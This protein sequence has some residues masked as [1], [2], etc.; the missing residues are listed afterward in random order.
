VAVIDV[1]GYVADLKD[2]SVDHGFHVHDERHFVETYSLRQAFE[3]E[4]HPEDGCEG[5]LDLH[6]ALEV[7]PRVLL[8]FEDQ[9][10]ALPE[11]ADPPED[12]A[13]PLTFTWSLPPVSNGPDLLHLAIDLADIGGRALPLETSAMDSYPS[14]TAEAERRIT[15]VAKREVS[16]ARI[17]GGEELLCED[18]DRALAVSEYLLQQ[19]PAWLAQH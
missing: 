13:L 19:A 15:I 1:A 2:H 6:L 12:I 8:G 16:L 17:L 3:V 10:L 4:L 18:F 14:A 11:G 7:D 5:P 9:V